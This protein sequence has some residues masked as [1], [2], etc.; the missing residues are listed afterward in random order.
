MAAILEFRLLVTSGSIPNS[1]IELLD[2][3]N[4]GLAVGT[5]F[6]S[7]LEALD[8][9]TFGLLAAILDFRFPVTSGSICS[10]ARWFPEPEN[11]G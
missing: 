8:I 4:G 6:L 10:I 11:M 7:C 5:A 2:P 9:C 3:E 1:A